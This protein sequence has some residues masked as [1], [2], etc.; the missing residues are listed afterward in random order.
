ME[1][2]SVFRGASTLRAQRSSA[3]NEARRRS[4]P[5]RVIIHLEDVSQRAN[6]GLAIQKERETPVTRSTAH[7]PFRRPQA[8]NSRH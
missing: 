5:I 7:A 3:V 2:N 1:H 4:A 8:A 6:S